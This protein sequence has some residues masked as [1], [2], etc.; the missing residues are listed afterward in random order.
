MRQL[1]R[2][3]YEFGPFRLET[4]ERVLLREGELVPLTPKA[5]ET[6]L[7]LVESGGHILDKEDLLRK[8]WPDTFVEEVSLAKKVSILRKVLG[9][10]VDHHYIETIPRRGYRFVAEVQEIWQE[11][12]SRNGPHAVN[13]KEPA[14]KELQG[15]EP[16]PE[17]ANG[18]PAEI[19]APSLGA[20]LLSP[21]D[22]KHSRDQD[23]PLAGARASLS[24]GS[25]AGAALAAFLIG[26]LLAGWGVW[27]WGWRPARNVQKTVLNAVPLT[28]YQGR[29]SQVAFS[30]DG[31]QIAFV[32]NGPQGDN[33]DIYVKLID[34]ETPL[35]LTNNPAEDLNPV[36]SPDGRYIVFL[37]QSAEGGEFYL[38]PALGGAERKLTSIFPFQVPS[39]GGS[40]YYSPDGK[41]LAIPDKNS[42]SEPLS[43]HLLS[44]ETRERRKLTTPPAGIIGDHNPAFSPDGKWLAFNRSSRWSTEDLYVMRLAGGEPK[45]LTFDNMTINGLAWTPDSREILFDSRRGGSGKYLW[46]VSVAGGNPERVETGGNDAISP[47]LSLTGNRLAY[48]QTLDDLNIWRIELDAM[49]KGKATTELIAST[50]NDHGPDYSPDGRKIVFSSGR[51]GN[52]AIWVCESDGSKPRLLHSCGPYVTGTPRWSPDGHWIAFDSRSCAPGANGN[53]DI[54]VISADGGQ[55]TRMTAEPAENVAPSWSRDGRWIYFGSTRGGDMQIWKM[56]STGGAPTQVTRQGGFEGFESFDGKY[57]YYTK[58][59]AQ[60]GLWR[61]PTAGGQEEFVTDHHQVGLWRYWRVAEQGIYFATATSAGAMVEFYNFATKQ[62][63]EVARI[64]RAAEKFLPGLAVSPDGRSLLYCQM[65]RSGSDI[66]MVDNFR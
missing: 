34:A 12:V 46:R 40:H 36:W 57:L 55:P 22:S 51:S 49:G 11:D 26:G 2:H 35:R 20:G 41:F 53:P 44:I 60:P 24:N 33:S 23:R 19:L 58:G 37:R 39:D 61:T 8:V 29:E 62:I 31:N 13:G 56:P 65:D 47:A 52:S 32:W 5:F 7:A 42:P 16:E 10:D 18:R 54:Y 6:L 59:R 9:E 15:K 28:S 25:F 38:I 48:T 30:P 21:A 1:T 27:Q 17:I 50:F 14:G 64:A 66:M 45:R 43:I 63:I 4:G 3:Y